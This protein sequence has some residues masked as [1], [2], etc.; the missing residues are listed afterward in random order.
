MH[1]PSRLGQTLYD[2]VDE[3]PTSGRQDEPLRTE[4]NRLPRVAELARRGDIE[5]LTHMESIVE[6]LGIHLISA[7]RSS[8]LLQAGVTSVKDPI[9]YSRII[10]APFL[11]I[12]AE[13]LQIQF[14]KDLKHRRYLELQRASGAYQ[15]DH[16]N[17]N[18]LLDAFHNWCA[19]ETGATHFLTTDFKLLRAVRNHRTYR[20]RVR[21]VSPSE[22][23]AEID[24]E[25]SV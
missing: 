24:R 19:E 21:V 8:E 22:L 9:Q 7:G 2:L 13:A 16:V 6:F 12:S 5:L 20:P 18:G 1:Q 17:E 3:D 23:L 10:A 11:G 15:G 25:P 14:L 4:I